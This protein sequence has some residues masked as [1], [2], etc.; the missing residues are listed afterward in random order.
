MPSLCPLLLSNVNGG[1]VNSSLEI[2]IGW[3]IFCLLHCYFQYQH[4]WTGCWG[5]ERSKH[6]KGSNWP[7]IWA[8]YRPPYLNFQW[9]IDPSSNYVAKQQR[10]KW[11]HLKFSFLT[12]QWLCL[13][14]Y[15]CPYHVYSFL[16]PSTQFIFVDTESSNVKWPIPL[17]NKILYN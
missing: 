10:T 16:V 5:L 17:V 12:F 4:K 8:K 6:D 1:R 15:L 2:Q 13:I 14:L 9:W 3:S 7:Q 11:R